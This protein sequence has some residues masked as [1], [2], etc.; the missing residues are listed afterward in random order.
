MK[1][2]E[3]LPGLLYQRG[4]IEKRS[5]SDVAETLR[6]RNIS[7][8][9]NLH[10]RQN[11]NLPPNVMHIQWPI[12]DNKIPDVATLKGLVRF[13]VD[14]LRWG[15]GAILVHCNAGR[16][17]SS[18]VTAMVMAQY[19]G[20]SGKKCIELVRERRPNALANPHFVE[21]LERIR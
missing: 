1:M 13:L 4:H 5:P 10:R 3:I 8:V 16:N 17:R 7:I 2:Y 20:F 14:F 9:V 21:F 19:F 11:R 18:L 15:D 12:A 6:E